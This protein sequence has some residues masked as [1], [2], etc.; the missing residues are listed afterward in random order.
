MRILTGTNVNTFSAF[1]KRCLTALIFP[2]AFPF[3]A[4][5]IEFNIYMIDVEDRDNID[6]S[7]FENKGHITPGNYL[8]RVQI[9]K[10]TLPQPVNMTWFSA[11]NENGSQLCLTREQLDKFGLS[12][13]FINGLKAPAGSDCLDLS[14]TPELNWSLNKANMVLQIVVPQAWMKY[15]ARNWTS[16]E[17]W[18][19]GIAG[20]L[21]D[22]NV[23]ASQY[24]PDSGNASQNLSAYGTL[25]FNLGAWRLRSDFQYNQNFINGH[26]VYADSSL[27]RTWLYRP[28][29]SLAAKLSMGQY[30]LSSDIFDTFQF[31][32]ATLESDDSMLPPDLKGYAPQITGIAETNAK[33]TVSQSGRVLYQTNVPPGPFALSDLGETYQGQLDVDVEEE[34]GRKSTFQVGSA[35][36]P[37]LTRKGQVR[38]KTSVGKPGTSGTNNSVNPLFWTGEASWGWLSNVSLYGGAL[39]TA[40]DY[41]SLTSGVGFNLNAFGALSVDATGSQANLRQEREKQRGFSYRAN[42][43][44]RFESTGSQISFSGYRFSDENYVSMNEYLASRNGSSTQNNEKESYVLSFNQYVDALALNTYLNI[45]RNTYWDASSSTYY[46][47]S[48]SR[49]F[50]IGSLRGLSTSLSLSRVHWNNEDENQLYFS[51]TLPLES[52]RSLMYGYQRTGGHSPSHM[53]SFYDVTDRNNTWNISTTATEDDMENGEPS[54]RAGFQHYSPYGRMSVNGSLQPHHYNAANLGWNGSF[55]ATRF[56]MALHDYSPSDGARMMVDAQGVQGIEVNNT[57]SVTNSKGIAVVP[58]LASYTTS[59]VRIDS[60]KLPEGV[61]ITA[62]VLGTTL[63][64]GAIGYA[65]LSA[66][67]GYQIVGIVRTQ[68]GNYP[69][70]GI[71]VIEASSGREVGLVA[72]EGFVY[73]SGIQENSTLQLSWGDK[74]CEISPPNQSNIHESAIILPCKTGH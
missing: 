74:T 4:S 22:Y 39:L 47:L 27:P 70:L 26:S 57:R 9:N 14:H 64:Q 10:N 36:V 46:A 73:L 60:S 11:D 25:G 18:D 53:A 8:V 23:Y 6:I 65:Q 69:P 49:S 38:Y 32:G 20:M 51:F 71:S 15:Q 1:I 12:N 40:E 3:S 30:S 54:L 2:V 62:P 55:T 66:T 72:E 28:I 34:D 7:R 29:P 63:T 68:E 21:L 52:G 48:L 5:A 61:D 33:V 56:G 16:P 50:D 41:Q 31:T 24:D 44:R 42:Y 58:S 45:T 35:S 17:Y 19:E 13:D 43:A 59:T 67:K 37:Y